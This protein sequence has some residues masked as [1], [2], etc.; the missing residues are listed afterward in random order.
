MCGTYSTYDGKVTFIQGFGG[1]TKR[2]HQEDLDIDG[3]ILKLI[4]DL[5][6]DVD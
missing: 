5:K 2:D 3:K 6:S 1:K 4:L